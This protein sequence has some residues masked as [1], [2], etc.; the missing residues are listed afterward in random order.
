MIIKYNINLTDYCIE[1]VNTIE[2]I[3]GQLTKL[4]NR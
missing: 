3:F 2:D 4:E 1:G